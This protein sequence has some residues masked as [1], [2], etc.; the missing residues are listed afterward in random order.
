VSEGSIRRESVRVAVVDAERR[1]LLLRTRDP[2]R[3]DEL[4]WELPGG[5]VESGEDLAEAAVRELREETGITVERLDRRIGVVETEFDFDGKHYRQRE[6]VFVL[7]VDA[8][9]EL[10]PPTF[11]T[12]VEESAHLGH[13]WWPADED[14]PRVR[15]HPPQL[16]RLVEDFR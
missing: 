10:G 16:R 6:T 3:P 13:R 5:G 2:Q 12:P 4:W 9:P 8:A 15:V 14:L 11:A 1:L 7:V